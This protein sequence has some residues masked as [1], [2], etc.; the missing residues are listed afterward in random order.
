MY[1]PGHVRLHVRHP[2][3]PGPGLGRVVLGGEEVQ[4]WA[5]GKVVDRGAGL[6]IRGV[7]GSQIS[8]DLPN[9]GVFRK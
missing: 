9:S 8:G 4:G 2:H 7:A 6:V 1:E 5:L 3:S